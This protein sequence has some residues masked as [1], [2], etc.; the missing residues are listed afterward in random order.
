[1]NLSLSTPPDQRVAPHSWLLLAAL[2][3]VALGVLAGCSE[4][5]ADA[6]MTDYHARL[7]NTL[8]IEIAT[9][10]KAD[11][12]RLPPARDMRLRIEGSELDALDFLA[13]S[14]C[15]VQVTIGKRNSSLGKNA[16]PSQRLLLELEYLR[17][18][19]AC[20]EAQR[21]EG[22]D[23]LANTLESAWAQ[24]REQLP[25]LIFNATLGGEEFRKF[26]RPG[27]L[28]PNYPA[29]TS[30]QV[31]T[32]L[33][34]INAMTERWL[35]GD[36]RA[37]NTAFELELSEI[38]RGDGG[39]LIRALVLQQQ[40]LEAANTALEARWV[41]QPLCTFGPGDPT[42]RVLKTVIEKFFVG[43]V[44]PWSAAIGRRKHDLLA[45]VTELETSLAN[46]TPDRYRDWR[47]S[48]DE[49]I[50]VASDAP[51]RHVETLK[52]FL[53]PCGGV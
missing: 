9:A 44:Q 2:F 4:D 38:A 32:A 51:K 50:A 8:D 40:G 52:K 25:A 11:W 42:A 16:P 28:T 23:E 17:L 1:M 41:E 45:P 13:L 24:K 46:A 15:A 43:G 37:D 39:E 36:Y 29:Q 3:A 6:A 53:E 20:I 14:G 18:A 22:E 7:G 5:G 10:A 26:W 27:A 31:I 30:S 47:A 49:R 48:R 19:P 21:A 12:P 34:A 35:V 33:E